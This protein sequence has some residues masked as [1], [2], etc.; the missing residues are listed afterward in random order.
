MVLGQLFL[1][2]SFQVLL[3]LLILGYVTSLKGARLFYRP[4]LGSCLWISESNHNLPGGK[5]EASD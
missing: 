5:E 1:E 3:G 2:G 4:W